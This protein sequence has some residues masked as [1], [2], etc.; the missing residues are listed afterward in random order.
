MK[1]MTK[2]QL[3]DA[4]GV[5]PRTLWNW[6]KPHEELLRQMGMR[7]KRILPPNVVAWIA[8]QYCIDVDGH[9]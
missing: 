1:A 3:A 4:A 7:P 9:R 8:R 6:L 2:Q 5:S